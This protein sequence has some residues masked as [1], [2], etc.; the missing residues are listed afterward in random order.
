[1]T[2]LMT[3]WSHGSAWEQMQEQM[4]VKMIK[5]LCFNQAWRQVFGVVKRLSF[6]YAISVLSTT[7]FK[8]MKIS[9]LNESH[10]KHSHRE[11]RM[12]LKMSDLIS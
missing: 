1:M 9:E 11:M 12:S 4:D 6:M 10:L 7:E 8:I 2:K 5:E 3:L